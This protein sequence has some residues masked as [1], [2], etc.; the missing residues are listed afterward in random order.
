MIYASTRF[1]HILNH[2]LTASN[3]SSGIQLGSQWFVLSGSSFLQQASLPAAFARS[4]WLQQRSRLQHEFSSAPARK[5]T[6]RA[7]PKRPIH[8]IQQCLCCLATPALQI[9]IDLANLA[10]KNLNELLNQLPKSQTD[11][12]WVFNHVCRTHEP[13]IENPN[14]KL[15]GDRQKK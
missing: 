15:L 7:R 6:A 1:A 4:H 5:Q 12:R 9:D 11:L 10:A 14:R 13:S 3:R 2:R 8:A